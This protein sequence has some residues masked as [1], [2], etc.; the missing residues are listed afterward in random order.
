MS[1]S[2][3]CPDPAG[4][5][6]DVFRPGGNCLGWPDGRRRRSGAGFSC[7]CRWPS[8]ARWASSAARAA[9]I[10]A[11]AATPPV[12]EAMTCAWMLAR[13]PA[14]HTPPRWSRRTGRPRSG[15]RSPARPGTPRSSR[16]HP[17]RPSRPGR[18]APHQVLFASLN[19]PAK[20]PVADA[21]LVSCQACPP[22]G[23]PVRIP[24]RTIWVR[25]RP[26]LMPS[27]SGATRQR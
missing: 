21:L 19:D 17:P 2:V 18:A 25:R 5:G 23:R 15:F 27:S 7:W 12:A 10:A 26:C 9:L 11:P 4:L 1:A 20:R 14:T 22:V 3:A 8:M 16:S 24:S 6:A 13:L